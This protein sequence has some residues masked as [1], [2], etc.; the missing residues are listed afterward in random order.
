[1]NAQVLL[2]SLPVIKD[3]LIH[4][5]KNPGRVFTKF[6]PEVRQQV[7]WKILVCSKNPLHDRWMQ[8]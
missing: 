1:M 4:V 7:R 6:I 3:G 2:K 8:R 5:A